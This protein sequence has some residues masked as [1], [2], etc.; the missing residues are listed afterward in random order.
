MNKNE[1]QNLE[2]VFK[3]YV[4]PTFPRLSWVCAQDRLK[5]QMNAF[6]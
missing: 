4:S 1:T 5:Q 3:N 6:K 2:N